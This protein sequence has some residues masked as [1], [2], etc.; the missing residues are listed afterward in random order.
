LFSEGKLAAE[1]RDVPECGAVLAFLLRRMDLL[2]FAES[3]K[4]GQD[5]AKTLIAVPGG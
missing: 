3:R 4:G 5:A 2:L 1:R